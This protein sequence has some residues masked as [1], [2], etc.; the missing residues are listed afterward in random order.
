[1]IIVHQFFACSLNNNPAV[2]KSISPVAHGQSLSYILLN[3]KNCHPVFINFFDHIVVYVN[4]YLPRAFAG[5]VVCGLHGAC[6]KGGNALAECLVFGRLAGL[7]AAGTLGASALRVSPSDETSPET[8]STAMDGA[9]LRELRRNLQTI[10]WNLAGVVRT[11]D[12]LQ[13]GLESLESLFSRISSLAYPSVGTRTYP[14]GSN[15]HGEH[16]SNDSSGQH[17]SA[18]EPRLFYSKRLF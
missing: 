7:H 1:M 9:A 11:A 4:T 12:G 3:Q 13:K 16:D 15:E 14:R 17:G 2:L 8:S 6:R 18:G 10:A 5:E